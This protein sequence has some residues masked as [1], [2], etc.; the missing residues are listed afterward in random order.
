MEDDV[1]ESGSMDNYILERLRADAAHLL[2]LAANESQLQHRGLRGRFRELLIDNL[3]SPWLPPYIA[4]GTGMII[5][6]ENAIRQSTQD[7]VILYDRSIVPPVLV[8]PNHAPDG[9]FL[10]NSVIATRGVKGATL[11]TDSKEARY[12]YRA[13][14]RSDIRMTIDPKNRKRR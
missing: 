13:S 6:S 8:S 9:V 10:Y 7:D 14:V 1:M 12:V 11:P 2:H 5:A 3:L 4:S